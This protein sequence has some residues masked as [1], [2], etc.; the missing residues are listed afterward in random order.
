MLSE[1]QPTTN[2]EFGDILSKIIKNPCIPESKD[3]LIHEKPASGYRLQKS[4]LSD[5]EYSLVRDKWLKRIRDKNPYGHE[6]IG[7]SYDLFIEMV[8]ELFG[9]NEPNSPEMPINRTAVVHLVGTANPKPTRTGKPAATVQ[10]PN[11]KFMSCFTDKYTYEQL[12]EI[13]DKVVAEYHRQRHGGTAPVKLSLDFS[14]PE[15]E[16]L[17]LD[18]DEEFTNQP[19][20]SNNLRSLIHQTLTRKGTDILIGS[21]LDAMELLSLLIDK[22]PKISIN[23]IRCLPILLGISSEEFI[24]LLYEDTDS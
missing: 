9:C 3:L 5:K 21:G 10:E 17:Y 13:G 4:K 18:S 12:K 19:E 23:T 7:L 2:T 1:D 20:E 24:K 15:K 8:Q 16:T 14:T 11:L 22:N 6:T